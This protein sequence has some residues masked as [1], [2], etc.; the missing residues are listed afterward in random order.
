MPSINVANKA[1][2]GRYLL[3]GAT[4]TTIDFSLLFIFRYLFNAPIIPA[5]M[6]ST[7]VA[8]CFSFVANKKYAFRSSDQS[9]IR[10]AVLFTVLTLFGLWI[11]QN[12]II[13]LIEPGLK[14]LIGSSVMSLLAAKL[15]ATGATM[16]WNYF[17]YSRIVFKK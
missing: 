12:L 5:N 2:K 10:E 16:M 7:G 13:H 1:E 17:T 8:F 15:I 9:V 6:I 11:I 4:A 14:D 3:V